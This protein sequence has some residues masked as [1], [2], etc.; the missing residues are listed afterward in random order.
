MESVRLKLASGNFNI[1]I[2]I[3][4]R[5]TASRYLL[6]RMLI[7]FNAGVITFIFW[8]LCNKYDLIIQG[9]QEFLKSD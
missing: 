5:V 1:K 3:G 7:L 2:I 6:V 8:M 9:Q 4:F